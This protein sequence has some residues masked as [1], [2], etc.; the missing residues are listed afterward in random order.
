MEFE[1]GMG[2]RFSRRL[3][4]LGHES[5][6]GADLSLFPLESEVALDLVRWRLGLHGHWLFALSDQSDVSGVVLVAADVAFSIDCFTTAEVRQFDLAVGDGHYAY[7][8]SE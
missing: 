5:L 1:L 8:F 6:G 2:R 4:Q 7:Q 3:F